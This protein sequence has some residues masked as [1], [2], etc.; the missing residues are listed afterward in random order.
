[1]GSPVWGGYSVDLSHSGKRVISASPQGNQNGTQSGK[2]MVFEY[3]G[4][5]WADVGSSLKGAAAGERA[6]T[7]V[8]ISGDG[9]RVASSAPAAVFFAMPNVGFV[10]AYD[11]CVQQS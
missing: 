10:R 6:G 2:A 7:A 8:V 11:F 5:A 1:V 9:M 3:N 4:T